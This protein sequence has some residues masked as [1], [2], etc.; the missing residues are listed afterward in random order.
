MRVLGQPHQ[1]PLLQ[2]QVPRA[3]R[4]QQRRHAL[5]LDELARGV[6]CRKRGSASA[7]K[8]CAWERTGHERA[9][10]LDGGKALHLNR[11]IREEYGEPDNGTERLRAHLR[12]GAPA[13]QVELEHWA[14]AVER[15]RCANRCR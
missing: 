8:P 15:E 11:R 13:R 10:Q 4:H 6:L 14:R 2:R 9:L 3:A 12:A 1:R 5:A 7:A